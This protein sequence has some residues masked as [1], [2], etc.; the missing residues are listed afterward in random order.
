[1]LSLNKPA[2]WIT[3]PHKATH[4]TFQYFLWVRIRKVDTKIRCTD[5]GCLPFSATRPWT[6]YWYWTVLMCL[7]PPN[8]L[9]VDACSIGQWWLITL[10]SYIVFSL[11]HYLT[12]LNEQTSASYRP[13]S[14]LMPIVFTKYTYRANGNQGRDLTQPREK[15]C[16]HCTRHEQVLLWGR[17]W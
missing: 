5:F 16:L 2:T 1:M 3:T 7:L 12:T 6:T 8:I 9:S 17:G 13:A 15:D 10:L 11:I 14:W 4:H